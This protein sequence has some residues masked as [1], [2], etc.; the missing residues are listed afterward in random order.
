LFLYLHGR[1][2]LGG[3]CQRTGRKVS[4]AAPELHTVAVVAPLHYLG[5]DFIGPLTV[6]TSGSCYILTI[7]DYFSK[8]V[9]A[10]AMDSKHASGV[11]GA[12][13]KVHMYIVHVYPTYTHAHISGEFVQLLNVSRCHWVTISNIGCKPGYVNIYDNLPSIA[14]CTKGQIAAILCTRGNSITLQFHA[15]QH[16]GADCGLFA[17][18]YAASLCAGENPLHVNYIQH[19]LRQHL[20]QCFVDREMRTFPKTRRGKR[21]GR[22]VP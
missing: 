4:K 17:V 18:A 3:I 12:L 5:I 6:T 1:W 13:F 22:Q 10:F 21:H 16:E 15:K 9:H 20:W 8:F 7:S 14:S 11:A 2:R 19:Q